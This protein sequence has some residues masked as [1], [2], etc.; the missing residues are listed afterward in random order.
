MIHQGAAAD[1]NEDQ[2]IRHMVG[3]ELKDQYPYNPVRPGPVRVRVSELNAAGI[4]DVSFEARAG[5]VVGFAGL[6]G[7]GRTELA[8]A[9][10]G[11]NPV[12]SGSIEIDG[13]AQSIRAPS[14]GVRAGIGFVTE[15]RK[16]E[17]LIQMHG[18][19]ANMVLSALPKFST[20]FGFIDSLAEKTE[21]RQFIERFRIKTNSMDTEVSLLSGGNQQKVAIAKALISDPEIVIFDEPTRGVDVGAKREIYSLIQDLKEKGLCILLMSSDIPELLGISDRILVMARGRLTGQ[22]SREEATQEN[23]MRAAIL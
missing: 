4:T 19:R 3:R 7:A 18:V 11:A 22:L 2:L 16:H 23:I 9:L 12:Q 15:D 14:D 20:R 17:G 13:Q 5:E 8:K 10:F 6:M 1:L 21:I